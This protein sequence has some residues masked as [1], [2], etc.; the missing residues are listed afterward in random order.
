MVSKL[1][2]YYFKLNYTH[3]QCQSTWAKTAHVASTA[4]SP[5]IECRK[6]SRPKTINDKAT[7]LNPTGTRKTNPRSSTEDLRC[8]GGDVNFG[9][10]VCSLLAFISESEK[11]WTFLSTAVVQRWVSMSHESHVSRWLAT[12]YHAS[13]T[14][15]QQLEV[16]LSTCCLTLESSDISTIPSAVLTTF[17]EFSASSNIN[18][19]SHEFKLATCLWTN[20]HG[21]IPDEVIYSALPKFMMTTI[22]MQLEM[23]WER[24]K[25]IATITMSSRW[26]R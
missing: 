9:R 5:P 13:W 4:I 10:M 1:A 18:G 2:R 8:S 3:C 7:I 21:T 22:S 17:C 19:I 23:G 26:R 24:R 16:F 14:T 12:H 25:S 15:F 6:R 20:T 11:I